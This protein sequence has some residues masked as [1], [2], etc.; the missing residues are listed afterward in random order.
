M[1]NSSSVSA[2]LFKTVVETMAN[3]APSDGE[4]TTVKVS[5][6]NLESIVPRKSFFSYSAT[7][8]YQPCSS[9]VDLLVYAPLTA[10]LD[11]SQD[12]L[13]Q[14]AAIIAS[15][16]YDIKTGPLLFYN[17]KGPSPY[18]SGNG[19]IYIDCQPV[20]Q[21]EETEQVVTDTGSS[22]GTFDLNSLLNNPT[23]KLILG[24]LIFVLL[25]YILSHLLGL[26]KPS[27]GGAVTETVLTGGAKKM[28]CKAS[29]SV[30]GFL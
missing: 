1:N 18:G 29:A 23:F 11:I 30:G 27:K 20:G 10:C 14:M 16:P 13:N 9:N 4:S 28:C 26:L 5:H 6:Y 21:S 19:Q 8:P 7:E 24:S 15:N 25:L 22:S 17:E 3:N 12:T 2:N